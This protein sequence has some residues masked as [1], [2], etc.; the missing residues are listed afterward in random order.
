[1]DV[2]TNG[3]ISEMNAAERIA[4]GAPALVLPSAVV[5]PYRGYWLCQ[6]AGWSVVCVFNSAFVL[7]SIP[8]ALPEYL[9]IYGMTSLAGLGL[10][11]VWRGMLKR[12]GWLD[13]AAHTPWRLLAMW[14]I[15][16]GMVLMMVASAMFFIVRPQGMA[17]GYSWVPSAITF[18]IFTFV[19]WT[20]FYSFSQSR[21]RATRLEAERLRLEV[22]AKDAELRALQ[23]QIN[24]HFY[25]NSLNSLR[26]LIYENPNAAAGMVDQL[27]GLMRY[28]L[29]SSDA[30]TVPLRAEM[31]AVRAYLAIE[32]IRFEDR[33]RV[34]ISVDPTCEQQPI[35]PM[36][37]QTLVENAVKYGVERSANGSDIDITIA[38]VEGGVN[39]RVTNSGVLA[40]RGDSTRVGF[41]NSQKR[42]ALL[43]GASASL[44]L[45]ER[46]G[47]VI[48]TLDLPFV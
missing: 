14:I 9:L 21:R 5:R 34:T 1:M 6:I 7:F 18:W 23:A 32:K 30:K 44:Q 43:C 15:A 3:K 41:T 48:A 20:G 42:L 4:A 2:R 25:F 26:A 8:Q 22:L 39:V 13:G 17:G 45:T 27:A 38:R 24:P 10:S 47:K 40:L 33:L 11:H 29:M 16:F 37:V 19:F 31:D 12:R 35:P 36:T 28:T 46:D